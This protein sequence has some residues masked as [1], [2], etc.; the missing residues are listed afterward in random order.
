MMF[1]K[2]VDKITKSDIVD[3]FQTIFNKPM[4]L[5]IISSKDIEKAK[6]RKILSQIGA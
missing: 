3:V 5:T 1:K 4:L 2:E 6:L